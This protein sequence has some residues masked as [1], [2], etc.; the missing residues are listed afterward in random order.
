M[1]L[2]T[3]LS[4]ET[5]VPT[6]C[7]SAGARA[8]CQEYRH[9]NR[10]THRHPHQEHAHCCCQHPLSPALWIH[11]PQ[12]PDSQQHDLHRHPLLHHQ[13]HPPCSFHGHLHE[14]TCQQLR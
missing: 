7:S 8:Q 12:K 10:H 11:Q 5:N 4:R 6:S 13:Q 1:R 3:S 14:A 9:Q 2:Q